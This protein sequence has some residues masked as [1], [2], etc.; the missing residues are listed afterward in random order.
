MMRPMTDADTTRASTGAT[1][2]FQPDGLRRALSPV[3]RALM[4]ALLR[5]GQQM[6]ASQF[7]AL[8]APARHVVMLGDSITEG[9]LWQEWFAG[10]PVLNR[11]IS[12]ETSADLLRRLD[13]AVTADSDPVAV[14]LLVGTNDLTLGI[15]LPSIVGNVAA[16]LA[17]VERRA[18]GTPVVVQGVMPR[19]VRFRDDL[20][21]LNAAYQ[22]LVDASGAHVSYL[23]L[24]PALAD[25]RGVLRAELTRD[26]LHLTGEG[27][28]AWVGVLRPH[29][30]RLLQQGPRV[31]P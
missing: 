16:L 24:W 31:A 2:A 10:Q 5:R 3:A 1:D 12:G 11:G 27:Y 25:D 13:S 4:P 15:P 20:R 19:S 8:G 17:E 26:A 18:P 30:E 6:R 23:D 14:L 22:A 29:V 21:R 7:A 9:G 28:A